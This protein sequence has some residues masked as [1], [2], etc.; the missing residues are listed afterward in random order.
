VPVGR[1]RE[2]DEDEA[3]NQAILTFWRYGYDGA[4]LADLTAAMGMP[5]SSLYAVFGSKEDLFVAAMERYAK[6]DLA[7]VREATKQPTALEVATVYLRD[8]AGAVTRDGLPRGCLAI[9]GGL[10]CG[11]DNAD[12]VALTA[13]HRRSSE[14][15]LSR[16]FSRARKDGDLGAD[17]NPKA[18]A[19]Y[20]TA[21]AQ[22]NAVHAVDGASRADLNQSVDVALLAVKALSPT[23]RR[24]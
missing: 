12:I 21:V 18:L 24:T 10:S 20:L 2:F 5:K 15:L 14:R 17:T 6:R 3:L 8:S 1:P 4:S 23:G 16:R 19:R 7:Y 22:G 9:Q 11:P 13:E